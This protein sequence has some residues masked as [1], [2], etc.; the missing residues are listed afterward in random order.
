[1]I[2]NGKKEEAQ[3]MI[4]ISFWRVWKQ[5]S[6][7]S[8]I[9]FD[10]YTPLAQ[11][12][13]SLKEFVHEFVC[14]Q[15]LRNLTALGLEKPWYW[16][17]YFLPDVETYHHAQQI[18]IYLYRQTEWWNP[19]AGVTPAERDWLEKKYPGWND[20]F[21][22]VWDVITKNILNGNLDR[23]NPSIL[24]MMCS[25]TGLELTGVPGKKWKVED[26]YIDLDGRRYHF[27]S[28]VDKWIFEQEPGR[29]K[30]YMGFIDR[31]V[32]G[33]MP[34]G[35][36]GVYEYMSMSPEERGVCGENYR[37]ADAFRKVA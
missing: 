36:D 26:H 14:T 34:A 4:D 27:G 19:I 12:E 28:P 3:K 2:D 10:Y 5:F 20:T 17:E 15:F 32:A 22:T 21:G 13:Y 31:I 7:L 37:W 35:P 1:L 33:M 6:A 24:P 18:G 23:T 11:R 29:Y 8:G 16:D 30:N 9:A 25:M